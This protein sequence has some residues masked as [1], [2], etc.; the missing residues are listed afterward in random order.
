MC[1]ANMTLINRSANFKSSTLSDHVATDRHSRTVKEKDY[2]DSISTGDSTH[3][4]MTF[5]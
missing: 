3:P 5:F 2:E 1:R 4:E